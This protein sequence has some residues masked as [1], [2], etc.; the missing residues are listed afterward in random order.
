MDISVSHIGPCNRVLYVIDAK[1]W[2]TIISELQDVTVL[3]FSVVDLHS[4]HDARLQLIFLSNWTN[5]NSCS[6]QYAL[7]HGYLCASNA[8]RTAPIL[9]IGPVRPFYECYDEKT[10][11]EA[12]RKTRLL[13]YHN[14]RRE[15][16][17]WSRFGDLYII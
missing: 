15:T 14:K 9:E 3:I 4:C 13:C 11:V 17:K 16:R 8:V 7:S 10:A 2:A 1:K 5:R 6:G 12:S